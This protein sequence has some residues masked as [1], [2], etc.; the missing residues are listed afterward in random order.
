VLPNATAQFTTFAAGTAPL[1]Y[2]WY[3]C[4]DP[5]D[6]T[7]I[8]APLSPGLQ[9]SGAYASG[10][11]SNI[12]TLTNVTAA[13]PT[14]FVLVVT[15][16]NGSVTS[17]VASVSVSTTAVPLAFW[18]YNGYFINPSNPAPYQGIGTASAVNARPLTQF[19]HGTVDTFDSTPGPSFSWGTD[20][21]P[22]ATESNKTA[23]VQFNVSTVGAKNIKV[24]T[25]IRATTTPSKYLRFQFTTNGT[26]FV[27]YPSSTAQSPGQEGGYVP[28]TVDFTG[29]PG[30]A[31]NA[32]FGVRIVTE[33]ESTANYNNTNDDTYVGLTATYGT[34]GTLSYDLTTVTG[35]AIVGNN[36]PPTISAIPDQTIKDFV[37][38]NI[39][40]TVGDDATAPGSI[41]V[42]AASLASGVSV[43]LGTPVNTGGSVQMSINSSINNISTLH[44]P[45]LVTATD[46]N[47]DSTVGWFM[48]N[49]IPTNTP[50]DI[51]GL[52][53]TNTL[54]NTTLVIPFT[55]T[56]DHTPAASMTPSISSS[57][58]FLIPN[59]NAHL[60][61][62][63]SGT[64]R[65][66]TIT[67]TPGNSG[68][69]PLNISVTDGNGVTRAFT[70]YVV[71]QTDPGIIL[72]DNFN[73]DNVGPLA[74]ASVGFWQRH[75]GGTNQL[76]MGSGFAVVDSV[77][78]SEDVNA[79]LLGA[80][81]LTN[82]ANN[83]TLYASFTMNF[84][85]LP[86]ST[87]AY[88]AHF[89]D[90][91]SSGFLGRVWASTNGVAT[92]GT[93]RVGIGN[94]TVSTNN[95][96]QIAQDLLPNTDYT[97]VERIYLT[98]GFCTIW[99]N[100][101][102][103]LS[104]GAA[105]TTV[106]TNLVNLYSYAFRESTA[107]GGTVNV[108]HLKVGTSFHAVTGLAST[109]PA[110]PA[111]SI[112]SAVIGGAGGTNIVFSGTNNNG[113]TAGQYV[114]LV[115]TNVALPLSNWTVLSTQSFN[116]DGTFNYTNGIGP[117]SKRFYIIQ[118]LP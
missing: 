64:N 85:N 51:S 103:E 39:T 74:L 80:P 35:D 57:N 70:F 108:S 16:A 49:I 23:G 45:V 25:D 9:T 56:D 46:G 87:G 98:N 67:P 86:D 38:T 13:T 109:P 43:T 73:Y 79:P 107:S 53:N 68:T 32:N 62:G 54:T 10:A 18:T 33:F 37:G 65:T 93:Y 11:T 30:V 61:F 104:P 88:F 91:T 69:A 58:T 21:Y 71:V 114:V 15:G 26:D 92:G 76:Q 78:N 55:L 110:P 99:V 113:T 24:T 115:S 105:D 17:S 36:Q 95:T 83:V 29:I 96:A 63:G 31:N 8:T 3:F 2:Q 59:D 48:L 52:V 106:V 5:S 40:F 111:P 47:G 77:N 22:A 72:A 84:T 28:F 97:V 20:T 117:D 1:T 82:V 89:K 60:Q 50:P 6:N 94:S 34:S 44:T 90:N 116:A 41:A 66:L 112:S 102:S 7:Q 4:A 12:M 27:D 42:M 14:N 19:A 118:A 75:S 101:T 81:Y 100:P